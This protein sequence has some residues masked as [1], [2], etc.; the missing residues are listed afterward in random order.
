MPLLR[1][2]RNSDLVPA[3]VRQTE[4]MGALRAR[5]RPRC[6]RIQGRSDH[7]IEHGPRLHPLQPKEGGEALMPW[8]MVD[9]KLHGHRKRIR[10]GVEAMGLWVVAGSWCADHLT[11]GFIPDYVA[12]DLDSKWRSHSNSLVAAGFWSHATND[13]G[14]TGWQFHEWTGMQPTR[15]DVEKKREEAKER[16]RRSREARRAGSSEVRANNSEQGANVRGSSGEVRSTPSHPIPAH[17]IPAFIGGSVPEGWL[18]SVSAE[19]R[20]P[21]QC[22]K[23]AGMDDPPNC[24]R[25]ADAR[26]A[27]DAW[28]KPTL[29]AKTTKCGTH[30]K[31]PALN[32]PECAAEV[33]PPP[34]GWRAS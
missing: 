4:R 34:A 15:A 10:A 22:P 14:E 27:H 1:G 13:Q 18:T 7:R 26:K 24:R 5:T 17:P 21:R 31:H 11:D 20:P 28:Q 12:R 16:M 25:C 6:P 3:R 19:T 9:D 33:V 30:P 2:A 8:F 23:H 32:C 29:S